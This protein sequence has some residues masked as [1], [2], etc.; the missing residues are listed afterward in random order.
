MVVTFIYTTQGVPTTGDLILLAGL[1]FDLFVSYVWLVIRSSDQPFGQGLCILSWRIEN[2]CVNI[3]AMLVLQFQF[4]F[5]RLN[6]RRATR[7]NNNRLFDSQN[8]A[9]GGYNVGDKTE[10]PAGNNAEQQ[11]QVKC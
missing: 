6:E 9:R 1:T 3:S 7:Q 8:N 2:K 10:N 11:Y 4:H 5:T